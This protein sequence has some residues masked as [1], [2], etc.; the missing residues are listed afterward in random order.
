MK[1]ML[2]HK[3]DP[4]TEAGEM[5]PPQLMQEMGAY[6]GGHIQRGTLIDGAGLP[7]SAKRTRL[8][9]TNGR[10]TI[11]HGPYKG[12]HELPNNVVM[13]VVKTKDEAIGWCERYGKILDN[14]EIELGPVNEPWDLGMMEKPADAPMR[15]LLIEKADAASEAGT[16]TT[17]QKADITRLK[18]EMKKAGV[19]GPT[20]IA[21]EPSSHAKR[22]FFTNNDLRIVDG[23][24][25]EAKELIGGFAILQLGSF[26]EIIEECKTYAR[27][28][29]GTLEI[30]VRV[31]D[32]SPAVEG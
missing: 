7:R 10:A 15:F 27:I 32:E 23:P 6:I 2:M 22:L 30:D 31:L 3:N 8:T 16:R 11:K 12:E 17:K 14:G 13:L 5:P 4:K 20:D 24:F 28:L 19:L 26:D 1:F 21:L 9:F 29:G 25:A 18:T